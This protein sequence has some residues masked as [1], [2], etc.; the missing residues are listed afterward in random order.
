MFN[1]QINYNYKRPCSIAFCMFTS[2]YYPHDM[3]GSTW[4]ATADLR[5]PRDVR[6]DAGQRSLRMG[7]VP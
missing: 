6:R 2:G 3:A 7:Q 1:L 4:L 5:R